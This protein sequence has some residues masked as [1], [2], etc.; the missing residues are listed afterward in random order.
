MNLIVLLGNI[1]ISHSHFSFLCGEPAPELFKGFFY[2]LS[3]VAV[4]LI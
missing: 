2:T 4:D 1:D 3:T